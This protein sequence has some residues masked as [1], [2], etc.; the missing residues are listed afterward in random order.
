MTR[1][2]LP[3]QRGA[4]T[5]RSRRRSKGARVQGMDKGGATAAPAAVSRFLPLPQRGAVTT[6]SCPCSK[7]ARGRGRDKGTATAS[8]TPRAVPAADS[9][10]VSSTSSVQ[11]CDQQE[12]SLLKGYGQG[13]GNCDSFMR[14]PSCV[15]ARNCPCSKGARVRRRGKGTATASWEPGAVPAAA[16]DSV[17]TTSSAG[18]CDY[19]KSSSFKGGQGS[20]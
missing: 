5:A 1:S 15:T 7:G 12:S 3:P 10:S 11:W 18:W 16:S 8:W 2:L 9:D 4:V 6:R 13:Q 14:N 19:K 17:S 20:E